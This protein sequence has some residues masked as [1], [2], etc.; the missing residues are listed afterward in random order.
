MQTVNA[1]GQRLAFH[2]YW[3]G[4]FDCCIFIRAGAPHLAVR[5]KTAPDFSAFYQRAVVINGDVS[6]ADPLNDPG[7]LAVT[8]QIKYSGLRMGQSGGENK[9]DEYRG[10]RE[11]PAHGNTYKGRSDREAGV[12]LFKRDCGCGLNG[13]C[14]HSGIAELG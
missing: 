9:R 4:E 5:H 2:A 13:L 14:R 6:D 11:A 12:E 7:M 8:R 1:L 3:I 10:K